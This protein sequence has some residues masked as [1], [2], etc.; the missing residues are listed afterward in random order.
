MVRA[1][2]KVRAKMQRAIRAL[3]LAEIHYAVIGDQAIAHWV[4]SVDESATRNTPDVDIL[5][6][7]TDL[8]RAATAFA[9]TDLVRL[10]A[11]R[12]D[13]FGEPGAKS[14]DAVRI[15]FCGEKSRQQDLAPAPDVLETVQARGF[16]VLNLAA[17]VGLGLASFRLE[18]RVN[19]RD[20]LDVGL[21]DASWK[22]R[23]PDELAARLQELIDT[24]DG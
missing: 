21:I 2:E 24:P 7:R 6:H 22:A 19:L 12:D 15:A 17:L 16:W 23:Y 4:A 10:S 8:D 20:L 5:L 11:E 18:D 13:L 9:R 1:V 14:R 3:E